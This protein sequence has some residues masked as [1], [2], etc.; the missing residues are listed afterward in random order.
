MHYHAVFLHGITF[1]FRPY[2]PPEYLKTD[3]KPIKNPHLY[4]NDHHCT[5]YISQPSIIMPSPYSNTS[6]FDDPSD[7][8]MEDLSLPK[9]PLQIKKSLWLIR[10][11]F[12]CDHAPVKELPGIPLLTL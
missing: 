8:E 4:T 7:I 12:Q 5:A 1:N 2:A 9:Q 11:T 6:F 10:S 3:F